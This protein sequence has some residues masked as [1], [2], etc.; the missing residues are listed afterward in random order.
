MST[1]LAAAEE[2]RIRGLSEK[3]PEQMAAVKSQLRQSPT[4]ATSSK[5]MS[6]AEE[7][8]GKESSSSSRIPQF[9]KNSPTIPHQEYSND[10]SPAAKRMRQSDGETEPGDDGGGGGEEDEE[11]YVEAG[12]EDEDGYYNHVD[13]YGRVVE[14]GEAT[15]AQGKNGLSTGQ[16]C[17]NISRSRKK[18]SCGKRRL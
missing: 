14:E 1:F 11:G 17:I 12:G 7:S 5:K 16:C 13:M 3:T 18:P 4:A 2:L 15:P 10:G 8:G 9:P 6:A